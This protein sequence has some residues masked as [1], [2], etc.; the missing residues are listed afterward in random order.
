MTTATPRARLEVTCSNWERKERKK[1]VN[2]MVELFSEHIVGFCGGKWTLELYKKTGGGLQDRV[3][4]KRLFEHEI[5]GGKTSLMYN[6][7]PFD[8]DSSWSVIA[9]PPGDVN[10]QSLAESIAGAAPPPPP[11]GGEEDAPSNNFV[12]NQV[13]S[14][15]ITAHGQWEMEIEVEGKHP[16]VIPL[17]DICTDKFDQRQMRKFPVGSKL[18]VVVTDSS[19]AKLECSTRTEGLVSDNSKD[20]FTGIP[21]ADGS[22]RLKGFQKGP[23]G[24]NRVFKLCGRMAASFYKY[25]PKPLPIDEAMDDVELYMMEEYTK[26]GYEV[27]RVDHNLIGILMRTICEMSELPEPW[28]TKSDAGF[29]LTKFAWQELGGKDKYAPQGGKPPEQKMAELM[30]EVADDVAEQ[31]G[32]VVVADGGGSLEEAV[33]YLSSLT[34]SLELHSQIVAMK[35]QLRVLEER[36]A[37]T[38]KWLSENKHVRIAAAEIAKL[39]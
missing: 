26:D 25:D 4:F 9:H 5:S 22:L 34:R 7:R 37:E 20:V 8:R 33:M 29:T 38:D 17:A 3:I 35:E 1:A 36:K 10:V 14:A 13:Y 6:I 16:G 32:L 31:Q 21:N 24:L 23:Q 39:K 30:E 15:R 11:S 28:M 19:G 27:L 18:K 2:R 12:P